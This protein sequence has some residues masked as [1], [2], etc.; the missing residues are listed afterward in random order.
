[1]S[2]NTQQDSRPIVE[3]VD[4]PEFSAEPSTEFLT[5]SAP[6]AGV[7]RPLPAAWLGQRGIYRSRFEAVCNGEQLVDP[8]TLGE[9]IQRAWPSPSTELAERGTQ[10][11]FSTT[12]QTCR[13]D[14][15]GVWWN[16]SGVTKT[17]RECRHCGFFVADMTEA[18]AEQAEAERPEVVAYADPVAFA[19]FKER[20]HEGGVAGREWMWAEPGAALVAMSRTDECERIVGALRAKADQLR[21]ALEWRKENQAGQRELLRSVTA[22]RDAALARVAELE[23][24]LEPFA[25]VADAYD[26]SEDDDHEPYTDMG[27]DDRLRLTLGQHRAGRIALEGRTPQAQAQHS[28]PEGWKLVPVEPTEDVLEAIHNGGYVGDDQELRWF[29]QSILAAAPAPGGE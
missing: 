21:E 24:A 3:V 29:Y 1:M 26:D 13:H 6:C 22:E 25:A 12:E 27:C 28:V 5:G 10:H 15:Y 2:Q 23:T 7:S 14:F 19:T 17:G 8:L 20:G 16:D 18:A 11:R 4:L 9:L